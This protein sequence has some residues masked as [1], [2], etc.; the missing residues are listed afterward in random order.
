MHVHIYLRHCYIDTTHDWYGV[1]EVYSHFY[2]S[3]SLNAALPLHLY[4]DTRV[5]VCVYKAFANSLVL[6]ASLFQT[7]FSHIP[8]QTAFF[9]QPG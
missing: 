9:Q 3:T 8:C 6:T 2:K 1:A 4:I 5:C 7:G